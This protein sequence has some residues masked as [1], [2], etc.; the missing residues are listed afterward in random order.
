MLKFIIKRIIPYKVYYP[1]TSIYRKISSRKYKGNKFLCPICETNFSKF[2]EFGFENEAIRTHN[3]VGA[4][5]NYNGTC[6]RCL[7][8]DRERHV[9]LHLKKRCKFLFFDESRLLHIAPEKNLWELFNKQK[10]IEYTAAGFDMQL[11]S[12]RMDITKISQK[13][14][15]YDAIICNHVL[16][17]IIDDKLAMSELFR[18]LKKGGY[19]ILQVPISFKNQYTIEDDS[20]ID[21]DERRRV[22]GQSD[23]VR[24][25]GRDY[26]TRLENVGFKVEL[27]DVKEEFSEIEINKYS[28]LADE[29]IFVCTK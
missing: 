10:N 24:I 12:V 20:V 4:G 17:H 8:N 29:K 11:A 15:Y 6:P 1:F 21:P 19:A 18:V 13:S 5:L 26:I 28:L 14:D 2:F 16:E 7:S 27:F 3:I 22:F 9:F 25:Y 23:H